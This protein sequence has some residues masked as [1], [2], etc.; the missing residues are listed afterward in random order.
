MSDDGLEATPKVVGPRPRPRLTSSALR[1]NAPDGV[2]AA[3]ARRP[4]PTPMP[5]PSTEPQPEP[6]GPRGR[7]P[8]VAGAVGAVLLVV[9][10]LACVIRPAVD[11]PVGVAT[12]AG[13]AAEA[14]RAGRFDAPVALAPDS[15]RVET[16]VLDDGDLQVTHWVATSVDIDQVRLGLPTSPALADVDLSATGVTLAADGVRLDGAGDVTREPVVPPPG[17]R[18]L[19]VQYVL[20]GA[21][22]DSDSATGRALATVTALELGLAGRSLAR[23]QAFPGGDVLALACLGRGVRAV[24]EPC[25]ASTDGVW[26]VASAAGD[27]PVVIA[28]LDLATARR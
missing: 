26:Q 10:G 25:G 23:T 5:T 15:E 11:R 12:G 8:A 24:P 27:A 14:R 1:R 20:P 22:Q 18:R 3:G 19:Y 17:T 28:Q 13:S 7:R 16:E 9:L 21:V 6:V 4:Q 2:A